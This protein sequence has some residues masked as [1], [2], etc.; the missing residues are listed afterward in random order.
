MDRERTKWKVNLKDSKLANEQQ[1]KV[2]DLI[3]EFDIPFI[4]LHVI[5]RF[6]HV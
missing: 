5:G 4:F 2:Y 3:E 6:P 1:A